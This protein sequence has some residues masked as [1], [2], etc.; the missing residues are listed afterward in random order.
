MRQYVGGGLEPL[1]LRLALG[2]PDDVPLH[3]LRLELRQ[4]AEQV[5][6]EV[7]GVPLVVDRAHQ[8]TCGP[9]VWRSFSS[10]SRMRP[11]TVPIGMPSISAICVWV[12]PPK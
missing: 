12:K 4:G 9:R 2:A 1:E 11:F 3:H 7:L 6:A 10:P 5:G 8:A